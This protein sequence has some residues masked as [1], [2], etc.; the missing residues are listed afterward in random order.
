MINRRI[1]SIG[2]HLFVFT[3]G[4]FALGLIINATPVSA[5]GFGPVKALHQSPL[6]RL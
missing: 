1:H 3:A 2:K 5:D 6:I 4:V